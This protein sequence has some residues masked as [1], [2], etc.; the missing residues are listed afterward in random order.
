MADMDLDKRALEVYDTLC[1]ALDKLNFKYKKEG[2]DGDDYVIRFGM[3]GDDLPM[4]FVMFVDGKRQLVRILSPLP[5]VFSEDK[6]LEGAIVTCRANY[7]MVN[8]C[9]DYDYKTG[10]TL[11]KI[12]T[13]Y[14]GSLIDS[15]LLIFMIGL[16]N[17][18]VD[19]FNDKFF[20]VDKGFMSVE[21]FLNKY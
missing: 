8:G 15:D 6:R 2:K 9:F 17:N 10:R 14:R 12:T 19:E 11:F 16:A 5:F 18:M 3:V 13:S 20:A 7:R 21:D 1:A 4:D